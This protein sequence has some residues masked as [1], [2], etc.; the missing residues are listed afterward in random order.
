MLFKQYPLDEKKDVNFYVNKIT[1]ES[2]PHYRAEIKIRPRKI[3][4]KPTVNWVGDRYEP[5]GPEISGN[6]FKIFGNKSYLTYTILKFFENRCIAC[7][8]TT[9]FDPHGKYCPARG[10]DTTWMPC[11]SCNRA[12]HRTAGCQAYIK[13]KN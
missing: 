9:C 7:G 13:E 3:G 6:I 1:K 10:Q 2:N 8:L 4:W 12:F 11:Q 5:D